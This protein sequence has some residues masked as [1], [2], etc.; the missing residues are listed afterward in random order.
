MTLSRKIIIRVCEFSNKK[1]LEPAKR[2]FFPP[3]PSRPRTA[4]RS[5]AQPSNLKHNKQLILN[6]CL[7]ALDIIIKAFFN[8]LRKRCYLK[9]MKK[10]FAKYI[11]A[12]QAL[13]VCIFFYGEKNLPNLLHKLKM[14]KHQTARRNV[15]CFASFLLV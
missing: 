12:K 1:R 7:K 5:A 2:L 8:D 3:Q 9:W 15:H 6:T 10:C 4:L 11:F 14:L 13:S